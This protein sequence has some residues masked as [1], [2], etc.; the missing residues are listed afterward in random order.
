ME[1]VDLF[2]FTVLTI[3]PIYLHKYDVTVI[4]CSVSD[5]L[6]VWNM[7]VYVCKTTF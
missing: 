7:F 1:I 6:E 3:N 2:V 4:V 5:S